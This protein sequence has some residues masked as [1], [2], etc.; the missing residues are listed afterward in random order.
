M[1]K[2]ILPLYAATSRIITEEKDDNGEVR[3]TSVFK[4]AGF[5]QATW[6]LG[7]LPDECKETLARLKEEKLLTQAMLDMLG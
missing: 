3:K 5:Y 7:N 2:G 4:H 6:S 1:R